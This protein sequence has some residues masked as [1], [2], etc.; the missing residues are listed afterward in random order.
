[1][2]SL[3]P[4]LAW[5]ALVSF[6]ASGERKQRDEGY[7]SNDLAHAFPPM[8]RSHGPEDETADC[9]L[10]FIAGAIF[11]TDCGGRV[12]LAEAMVAEHPNKKAPAMSAGGGNGRYG[13][14]WM[15]PA[16][17]GLFLRNHGGLSGLRGGG[18]SPAK[19]VS[20][21]K[22]PWYQAILQ[23]NQPKTVFWPVWQVR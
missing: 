15:A 13:R 20:V 5:V 11:V 23:G 21:R 6:G 12:M 18:R 10:I 14:L 4:R 19:P 2:L 1:L 22:N 3:R 9:R 16:D 7:P 8:F 17:Q